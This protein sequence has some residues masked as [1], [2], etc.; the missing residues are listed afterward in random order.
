M[1]P[2]TVFVLLSLNLVAIGGLLLLI[3][4][5]MSG[6]SSMRGFGTGAIAFGAGYLLR[7]AIGFDSGAIHGI[8]ADI[9]MV[10]AMLCF[11]T[12]MVQFSGGTPVGRRKILGGSAAYALVA[13]FAT[14]LWQ[15]VGRH[16]VL[17]LTLGVAY[18]LLAVLSARAAQ[19]EAP[20]LR[21][22]LRTL[23]AVLAVIGV[24]TVVRGVVAMAVGLEPLFVGPAARAYYA[25][26]VVF[27]TVLGPLV[28][29][30]IF[31]RLNAQ[32]NE[33][34]SHDTLTRLLNRTGLEA[35]VQ[36]HFGARPPAPLVLM[37]VDVDHF[38][39]INDAHGH[40]AG[41][42]VL[43]GVAQTLKAQLRGVDFVSRWGG[44]EFMVCHGAGLDH[45]VA[46]AERL[47]Q[48]IEADRHVLP[49]GRVL[50]CSVSIGVSWPIDARAMW[51]P[52]ARAADQALYD[53]KRRGRN[54]VVMASGDAEADS[55]EGPL[56]GGLRGPVPAAAR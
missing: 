27:S 37:L 34:A 14:L 53:A 47:R 21:V 55:A 29:W 2:F 35:A 38:K 7:I 8:V 44:E 17:N 54:R 3:S 45:A 4:R 10:F 43:R 28:L 9:C 49:D 56:R 31:V 22:P 30:M 40:A 36:R 33:L 18:G 26:S 46:L 13:L 24:A 12:A 6:A 25:Y 1:D 20:T 19:K 50:Q 51:E 48:A 41:D 11:A 39:H 16:A 52:A 42:I 32:L 23:T 5:S 15:G